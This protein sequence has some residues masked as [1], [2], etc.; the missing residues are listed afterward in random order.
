M[1]CVILA[2]G[3]GT[4]MRASAPDTAKSMILVAGKPFIAWQLEW[5]G[6]QGVDVRRSLDW[7]QGRSEFARTSKTANVS[8]FA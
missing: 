8:A 2:G 4:R 6:M 7:L 1:Q 3:L 5:L